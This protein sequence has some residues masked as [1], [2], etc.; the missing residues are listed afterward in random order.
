MF[1]VS[2]DEGSLIVEFPSPV[3]ALS[4]TLDGGLAHVRKVV[5]RQVSS[6]CS[7][8]DILQVLRRV[9]DEHGDSVITFL[10]AA[11]IPDDVV[12]TMQDG[13]LCV[14]SAG[15][16]NLFTI[17]NGEVIS[18]L[19]RLSHLSTINVLVYVN[20][21]LA[22]QD[23][24]DI[25]TCIVLAKVSVFI[26]HDVVL[27]GNYAYGTTSDAYVVAVR[28]LTTEFRFSGPYTGRGRSVIRLV[29]EALSK[30][31]EQHGLRR[32]RDILSRV[33]QFMCTNEHDILDKLEEIAVL[34]I[35]EQFTERD[36]VR[37]LFR[38][39][40][41]R[42]LQSDPNLQ[43]LIRAGMELERLGNARALPSSEANRY[44]ASDS[45]AFLVDEIL[46]IAL[47]VALNG[48]YG[49]FE[50][51]RLD[52]EKPG[53]LRKLPPVLDDLLGALVAGVMSR[54]WSDL[55]AGLVDTG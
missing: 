9:H 13:V 4:S 35:P 17:Q 21:E 11:Q 39:Y 28:E 42:L 54:I 43:L 52:R 25:L 41:H 20:D 23:M 16:T 6:N 37:R 46:G 53:L 34:S 2:V 22:L 49:L 18:R 33:G 26:D 45:V 7:K 51:Y 12:V 38:K 10:T 5:F 48:V 19:E 47:A 15:F 31:L 24:I 50:Y 40:L 30:L 14:V 44:Y 55:N 3:T 29:Y 8:E 27:C 1:R 36:V 32:D